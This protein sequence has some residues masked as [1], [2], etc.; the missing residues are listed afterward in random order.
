M[1]GAVKKA[2]A[3]SAADALEGPDSE[4]KGWTIPQH[5]S[6][7]PSIRITP[8]T[9]PRDFF[10]DYVAT[11]KPCLLRQSRLSDK[12]WRADQ[13]WNNNYLRRVAG[14]STVR[15][16][17]RGNERES[18]GRGTNVNMSFD[19]VLTL[20]EFGDR[21][22]YM[23]TQEL[24]TDEEGRPDLMSS[25]CR[26]LYHAGDFPLV[27]AL[28]GNLLPMNYNLWLGNSRDGSSS[29]LHHDFHD[30]L[31]VL[32]R[33]KKRFRLFSPLDAHR[34]STAGKIARVHPNGRICY[35]ADS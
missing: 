25:P 32:L 4:Y 3:T 28:M 19:E 33:G 7:I 16:E 6:S 8:Q 10:R 22:H 23:T 35:E 9:D 15:V 17:K 11:R 31:Y 14:K 21:Y 1:Q 30:N 34:L 18:F 13:R 12:S 24:G 26:E 20:L 29:G 2:P 27:P 5:G